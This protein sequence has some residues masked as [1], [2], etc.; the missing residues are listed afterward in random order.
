MVFVN[1]FI[2]GYVDSS[3]FLSGNVLALRSQLVGLASRLAFRICVLKI[4][5]GVA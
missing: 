4:I 2:E 3:N 5:R 1:V